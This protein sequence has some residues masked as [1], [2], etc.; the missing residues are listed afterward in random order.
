MGQTIFNSASLVGVPSLQMS[1]SVEVGKSWFSF[2]LALV[3]RGFWG[4]FGG[5]RCT[6]EVTQ[7][8]IDSKILSLNKCIMDQTL[9]NGHQNPLVRLSSEV[10]TDQKKCRHCP[11]DCFFFLRQC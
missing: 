2:A 3:L 1:V 7:V 5:W 8:T 11:A 9:A 10:K 4:V 6:W